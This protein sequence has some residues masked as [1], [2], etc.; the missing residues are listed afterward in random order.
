MPAYDTARANMVENQVRPN[1]VTDD[2]VLKAMAAVPRER[3][4]PEKFAGIAYVDE[5]IAVS[6]GRYLMEPM[7][8]ARLLQAAAITAGDVVLDIGCATGYS[9]A[10]LARLADTV[11][12]VESEAG[13]AEAAIAL[14]TEL[15]ADNTAV[16][17]GELAEGYAKQ[18]PYDVIVLEG[19]VEEVPRALSDQLVEGGRMVA[20][21]TGANRVGR[22]TLL[23]RL[24]GVLSSRVLFDA[25]VPLLPG[26]GSERGFVFSPLVL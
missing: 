10:V 8:L 11:V 7:V 13:L 4:V 14:M 22:A 6:E 21:V 12:A 24:H 23:R 17:T 1:K 2:R 5:D 25:S 3:F 19:A 20:V 18:A 26:F 16:V 9:T 15:D